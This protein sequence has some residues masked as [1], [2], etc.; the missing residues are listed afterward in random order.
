MIDSQSVKTTVSGGPSGYDAGKR[1]NGR[2]RHL[3][4]D[5]EESPIVLAVH[6]ADIQH[7]NAA[8]DLIA[9]LLRKA[10]KGS[11]VFVDRGYGAPSCALP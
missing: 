11:K 3:T 4:V 8:P 6:T 10:H 7:R 1:I 5:T 9:E 2:K